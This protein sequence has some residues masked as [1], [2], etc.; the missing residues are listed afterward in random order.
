MHHP[1]SRKPAGFRRSGISSE[2]QRL[3]WFGSLLVAV[4]VC[5]HHHYQVLVPAQYPMAYKD[6]DVVLLA[7]AAAGPLLLLEV[8]APCPQSTIVRPPEVTGFA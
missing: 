1:H 3:A 2:E 8:L 6:G 7:H 5:S 4:F